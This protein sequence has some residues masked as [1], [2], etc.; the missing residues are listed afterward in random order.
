MVALGSSKKVEKGNK[1]HAHLMFMS[2]PLY[3]DIFICF[4]KAQLANY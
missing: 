4:P 3:W 1:E 2:H